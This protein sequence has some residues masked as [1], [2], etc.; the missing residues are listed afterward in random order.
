M[1][2]IELPERIFESPTLISICGPSGSG[3]SCIV[4]EILKYRDKLFT[5]RVNGVLYFYSEMQDLFMKNP[6]HDT[7]FHYGMPSEGDL[8]EYIKEYKGEHVLLIFD[9]LG[10]EVANSKLLRD[11]STKMSHHRNITVIILSQN[12]YTPGKSS[13]TQ[14]LNSHYFILTRTCRDLRQIGVLGSQLFP[15]KSSKFLDIYKDAV[16]KP[17]KENS[18][19][20]LL[21]NCHPFKSIRNC[22][23]MSGIFPLD[24][25]FLFWKL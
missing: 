1:D 6:P 2:T 19:P 4:M 23:L 8:L 16:D 21:I 18:T 7:K 10:S 25:T 12:I 9:D 22:Q 3:K 24:G 20:F 11:I 5:K 13:R 15:G 17:F 14:S